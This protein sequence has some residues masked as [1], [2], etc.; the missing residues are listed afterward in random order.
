MVNGITDNT[1]PVIT[2]WTYRQPA[3][4]WL[5]KG[6]IKTANSALQPVKI[7]DEQR[8]NRVSGAPVQHAPG[9]ANVKAGAVISELADS[10]MDK[11]GH[12]LSVCTTPQRCDKYQQLLHKCGLERFHDTPEK[13]SAGYQVISAAGQLELRCYIPTAISEHAL[14]RFLTQAQQLFEH[15]HAAEK[16]LLALLADNLLNSKGKGLNQHDE[17]NLVMK[18]L[19]YCDLRHA[20]KAL[21][22]S[23]SV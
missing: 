20:A 16:N 2:A 1:A 9:R 11:T 7:A 6:I 14:D 12:Y 19:Q 21:R 3:Q 15:E 23:T 4:T 17:L 8:A 10:K 5:T 18:K 22:R 13:N